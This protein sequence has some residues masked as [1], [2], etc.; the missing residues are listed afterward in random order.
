MSEKVWIQ[1]EDIANY[2]DLDRPNSVILVAPNGA[3]KTTSTISLIA[4]RLLLPGIHRAYFLSPSHKVASKHAR[5]LVSFKIKV[6]KYESID[7]SCINKQLLEKVLNLGLEPSFACFVCPYNVLAIKQAKNESDVAKLFD[8]VWKSRKLVISPKTISN[9]LIEEDKVCFYPLIKTVA[10][11]SKLDDYFDRPLVIATPYH[12]FTSR[13][14]LQKWK[15][16][17]RRQRKQRFYVQVFDEADALLY[18]GISYTLERLEPTQF[19]RVNAKE[20]L[21]LFKINDKII[22]IFTH[23]I[24]DYYAYKTL[25]KYINRAYELLSSKFDTF[26]YQKVAFENNAKTNLIKLIGSLSQLISY[27][28][29]LS[30]IR[31]I[32]LHRAASKEGEKIVI[33][34]R[35]FTYDIVLN[36]YYPFKSWF[37]IA[38]TGT[39][40]TTDLLRQSVLISK[41]K[42]LLDYTKT[43]TIMPENVQFFAFHLFD[44]GNVTMRNIQFLNKID[45]LFNIIKNLF[46][47]YLQN[48]RRMPR[49]ILVVLQSKFQY[50]YM[51]KIVAPYTISSVR[52]L[53][54]T[55]FTGVKIAFTYNASPVSRGVDYDQYDISIVVGPLLRPPR[56]IVRYDIMDYA[57]AVAEAVQSAFRVV[58]ALRPSVTKYVAFERFLLYP[59]Y[60]EL[61]PIWLKSLLEKKG[62]MLI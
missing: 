9:K 1:V 55:V 27:R 28:E 58:R 61:L 21:E 56:R 35:D 16:Y 51:K 32:T 30:F 5:Q 38:L 15:E 37:K 41:A 50:N 45:E 43:L 34:D 18:T 20:L 49:G 42:K 62:I 57:R 33:E 52:G 48:E 59:I 53:V 29:E 10:L 36:I 6:V 44:Y 39:L 22:D 23:P 2:I 3:G 60:Y 4:K 47:I 26:E 24:F 14:V 19:D 8:Q 17:A 12:L 46:A 31:S 25:K 40:P 54:E 7:R 11:E 13:S